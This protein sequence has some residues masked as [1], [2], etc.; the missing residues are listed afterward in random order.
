MAESLNTQPQISLLSA[1]LT[2][3]VKNSYLSNKN[4]LIVKN[5]KISKE[6]RVPEPSSTIG[7]F[8]LGILGS[9]L[10]LKSKKLS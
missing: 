8:I 6:V 5:T 2:Q 10:I 1:A 4:N 7:L 9:G 3:P